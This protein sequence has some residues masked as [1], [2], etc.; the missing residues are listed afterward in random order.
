MKSFD[1][2][3]R[4][5]QHDLVHLPSTDARPIAR[6][7][8]RRK[9]LGSIRRIREIV[10]E[11]FPPLTDRSGTKRL[12]VEGRVKRLER[13]GWKHVGD[14]WA[15]VCAATGVPVKLPPDGSTGSI[16]VPG[17][18]VAIGAEPSKL[19]AAHKSLVIRRAAL[20]TQAL[21]RSNP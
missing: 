19:R 16:W 6:R 11:S 9:V 13:A 5:L 3:L 18:V 4:K 7:N 14:S 8:A 1:G 15:A 2:L 10:D 20:A 17:W 12:T 21:L